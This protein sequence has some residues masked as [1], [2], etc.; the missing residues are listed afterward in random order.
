MERLDELLPVAVP[1]RDGVVVFV[2]ELDGELLGVREAVLEGVFGGVSEEV[3]VSV[4]VDEG[5]APFDKVVVGEDDEVAVLL[6]V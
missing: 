2:E 3:D 6:D 1:D 4:G 5:V